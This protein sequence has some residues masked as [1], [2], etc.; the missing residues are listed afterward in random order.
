[1]FDS[2][3]GCCQF[4][5]VLYGWFHLSLFG[6]FLRSTLNSWWS[7]LELH[8]WW[9]L[10]WQILKRFSGSQKIYISKN[11]YVYWC[12]LCLCKWWLVLEKIFANLWVISMDSQV[13]LWAF[14]SLLEKGSPF[15]CIPKAFS[16][17][18]FSPSIFTHLPQFTI[19]VLWDQ[20]SFKKYSLYCFSC[21][22]VEGRLA[23]TMNAY[24]EISLK[25][26]L[27][28]LI[29]CLFKFLF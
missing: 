28:I 15:V 14:C 2:C 19:S 25:L 16:V 24:L 12:I 1:M 3:Q 18:I 5:F 27:L 29:L 13:D 21:R 26:L 4:K 6:E 7:Q 10:Y 22:R 17:F 11:H 9:L 20:S 23:E 8:R